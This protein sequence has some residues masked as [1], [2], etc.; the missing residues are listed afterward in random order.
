MSPTLILGD[1]HGSTFWKTAIAENPDCRYIFLGDYLDPYKIIAQNRLLQNLQEII[2]LKKDNPENVILLLGNHDLHYF[3]TDILP[4][5]RFDFLLAEQAS[6]MFREN[7]H[8]FQ[9]AFQDENCIFTHAGIAHNWFIEDFKG[10]LDSN[11]AEQL[12]NPKPEQIE[13][14][15]RCGAARGGEHGTVGGI[16][17]ADIHE[18]KEPLPGFT[19]IVGHNRVND[20]YDRTNNGGRIIFCDCLWNGHY[21]KI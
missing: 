12:N 7:I 21:L 13:A 18:L 3:T 15:C 14:L 5:S 8:L 4:S 17:W 16:F 1:I 19:Q 11:I 10:N 20:I 9:Y 6:V 2:Q